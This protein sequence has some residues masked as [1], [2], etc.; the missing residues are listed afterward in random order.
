[1]TSPRA[2]RT[3]TYNSTTD[4]SHDYNA[5]GKSLDEMKADRLPHRSLGSESGIWVQDS[6][7]NN[8]LPYLSSVKAPETAQTTQIT[9]NIAVAAYNKATYSFEKSGDVI[10]VTM[11]SNGNTVW[12]T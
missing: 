1:M 11:D 2:L 10:S 6:E 12:W 8:G 3:A 9:V 7:H 5:T 4:S